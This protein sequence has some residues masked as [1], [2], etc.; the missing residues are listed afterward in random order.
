ME[1]YEFTMLKKFANE[2]G[3]PNKG[4]VKLGW[5]RL[6]LANTP[7]LKFESRYYED[8]RNALKDTLENDKNLMVFFRSIILHDS[9]KGNP[10]KGKYFTV[11][12]ER[13][14]NTRLSQ[15]AIANYNT[16]GV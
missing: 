8:V 12:V 13:R 7:M 16:I 11:C 3:I 6:A 4:S 10:P 1:P 14:N 15:M 9:I 5:G 2:C